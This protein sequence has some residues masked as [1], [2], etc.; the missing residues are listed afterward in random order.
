MKCEHCAKEHDGTFATGRFC[1]MFCSRAFSTARKRKAINAK[2]SSALAGR[3]KAT[4]GQK[5]GAVSSAVRQRIDARKAERLQRI[6][7]GPWDEVPV[8]MRKT[9]VL[10]EQN[11]K[12]SECGISEWVGRPLVLQLDHIS[13]DRRDESRNNLRCIC[14]NCHSQTHTWGTRNLTDDGKARMRA[15]AV[16]TM[17]KY[18]ASKR[19]P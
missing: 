1:S 18:N 8:A 15:A 3:A 12:C 14:P 11:G 17:S 19:R 2:V 13:G 6:L 10:F 5:L 16:R 4:K 9:R 7:A